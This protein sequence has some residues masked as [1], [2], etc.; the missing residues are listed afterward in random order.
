MKRPTRPTH[1]L[2]SCRTSFSSPLALP[3]TNSISIFR[4]T[5]LLADFLFAVRPCLWLTCTIEFAEFS[6]LMA[7]P[8]H[9]PTVFVTSHHG[10]W[11]VEKLNYAYESFTVCFFMALP[12]LTERFYLPFYFQHMQWRPCTVLNFTTPTDS[13]SCHGYSRQFIKSMEGDTATRAIVPREWDD[14]NATSPEHSNQRKKRSI[15]KPVIFFC[16]IVATEKQLLTPVLRFNNRQT[17][18]SGSTLSPRV[19]D[20]QPPCRSHAHLFERDNLHHTTG[21]SVT[22]SHLRRVS[23]FTVSRGGGGGGGVR[24]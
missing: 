7:Y 3:G 2:S 24:G 12:C 4:T 9:K 5:F 20:F 16:K 13:L 23:S 11:P 6:T 17:T 1:F 21:G 22:L 18:K 15:S 19:C 14:Q 8:I 10:L